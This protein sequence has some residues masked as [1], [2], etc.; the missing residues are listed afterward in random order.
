MAE[1]KAA[2]L[3]LEESAY[4]LLHYLSAI[5]G[6]PKADIVEEALR[7][8]SVHHSDR[9][10]AYTKKLG[11]MAGIPV[12]TPTRGKTVD[13]LASRVKARASAGGRR[14]VAL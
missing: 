12:P 3:R 4:G 1:T 14:S 13:N 10:S 8:Y 11:E 9:V 2:N 7:D 5:E 6:R